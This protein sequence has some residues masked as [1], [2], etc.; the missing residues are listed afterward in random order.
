[1]LR[2]GVSLHHGGMWAQDPCVEGLRG[3]ST[4]IGLRG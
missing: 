3:L 1:M 4:L 2:V